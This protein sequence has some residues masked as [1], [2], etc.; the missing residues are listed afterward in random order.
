MDL[1]LTG[2]GDEALR[3]AA[4]RTVNLQA[5]ESGNPAMSPECCRDLMALMGRAVRDAAQTDGEVSRLRNKIITA[6]NALYA[7]DTAM[8]LRTLAD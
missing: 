3:S 4:T 8:A 6:R 7:S 1:T 5:I 2:L